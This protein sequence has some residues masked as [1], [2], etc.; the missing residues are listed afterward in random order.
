MI[1]Y[2]TYD[3]TLKHMTINYYF[4]NFSHKDIPIDR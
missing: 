3:S 2:R 4:I 1:P